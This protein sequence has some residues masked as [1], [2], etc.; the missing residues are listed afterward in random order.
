MPVQAGK[1]KEGR[2]FYSALLCALPLLLGSASAHAELQQQQQGGVGGVLNGIAGI[3]GALSGIG[4]AAIE[5]SKER[6]IEGINAATSVAT[7]RISADTSM[8]ISSNN[9]RV[10][11]E[12]TWAAERINAYNQQSTTS[13]LGAQLAELRS[14]RESQ[15]SLERERMKN[16][17]ELND[18]RINLAYQQADANYKLA[19][20]GLQSQLVQAGLSTGFVR[21]NSGSSIT[22]TTLLGAR[23]REATQPNRLLSSIGA[24]PPNY[25]TLPVA[26]LHPAQRYPSALAGTLSANGLVRGSSLGMPVRLAS[27][28]PMLQSDLVNFQQSV[29][30]RYEN[31]GEMRAR[32]SVLVGGLSQQSGHTGYGVSGRPVMGRPSGRAFAER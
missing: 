32:S 29:A 9:T 24:P 15:A 3:A 4:T 14:A 17:R 12:Q 16:E 1:K 27:A 10:A 30:P 20:M 18:M 6:A 28:S 26:R 22:A 23:I 13:R 31:R 5:A 19:Q 25:G 7:T 21:K 8:Y 11:L 2:N